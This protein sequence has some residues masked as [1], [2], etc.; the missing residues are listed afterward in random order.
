[1]PAPPAVPDGWRVVRLGDVLSLEYGKALPERARMPGNVPVV[2]SAGVVGEHNEALVK[3]PGIVIGRKGSIGRVTWISSDFCPIDTTYFVQPADGVVDLRWVY[4]ALARDDLSRL[5]R[6]TGVPG[7]NRDDVHAIRRP[8]PP[9][10]EQRRIAAVLDAIDEAIER[11]QAVV[12]ATEG[13]RRSLLHELLS[14]GLPGR[15]S[16]WRAIDRFRRRAPWA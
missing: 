12:A 2:G 16:A 9:L 15:H 4:Q 6:A 5:N 1:M 13:L 7:L 11:S 10:D 3:G 8:I 14:E